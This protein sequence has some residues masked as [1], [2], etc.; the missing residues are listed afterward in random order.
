[1]FYIIEYCRFLIWCEYLILRFP[2]LASIS[3]NIKLQ[4]PNFQTFVIISDS[5]QLSENNCKILKSPK[6]VSYD[7]T[8][9]LISLI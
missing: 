7:F 9:V 8:Q 6:D 1:M 2:C 3:E 5:L 4:A